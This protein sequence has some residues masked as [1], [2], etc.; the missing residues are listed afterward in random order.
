MDEI[1]IPQLSPEVQAAFVPI[2]KALGAVRAKLA[3]TDDV[4]TTRPGYKYPAD[5]APLP[6]VVVA[7]IPGTAP[8]EAEALEAEFGVPFAVIDATVEE[9]MAV[10]HNQT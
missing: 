2:M 1:N 8:V 6:A 7:I 3:E 10:T 5:G 4:V 9:Q